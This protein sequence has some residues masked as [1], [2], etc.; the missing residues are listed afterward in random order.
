MF[1]VKHY[2]DKIGG[3][4]LDTY[5][6]KGWYRMGQAVFTCRF[7]IFRG[8]LFSAIWIRLPLAGY[9]FSKRKRKR[10]RQL[11]NR[12]KLEIRPLQL[13]EEKEKLYRIYRNQFPAKIA[14]TLSAALMDDMDSSIFT[15]WETAVYDGDKLIAYSIFDLGEKAIASI[16]GVY[17][18]GYAKYSLGV[19][20][21]MLEIEYGIQNGF[22]YYYPGYVVPGYD[23]FNYKLQIGPVEYYEESAVSW[24]PWEEINIEFLPT[25]VMEKELQRIQKVLTKEGILSKLYLYPPYEANLLGFW[26]LD[27][28][29]YPLVLELPLHPGDSR[30]IICYDHRNGSFHFYHCTYYNDLGD[31]FRAYME[32][33]M[34]EHPIKYELLIKERTLI[35]TRSENELIKLVKEELKT[36]KL[37]H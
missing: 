28:L 19:F 33:D 37:R 25:A 20:T 14:P 7:L 15:T 8:K 1:T 5:L 26:I 6:Q 30:L 32:L 3:E 34:A 9:R 16:L 35:K 18:P 17:D 27:Y 21:M 36:R 13:T 23:K 24:Y 31:F 10:L 12:F 11:K 2:L 22:A 29:D 4:L